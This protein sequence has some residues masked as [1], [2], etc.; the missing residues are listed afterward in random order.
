MVVELWMDNKQPWIARVPSL[1]FTDF[2]LIFAA[3]RTIWI[4]PIVFP[5]T[6]ASLID[7][8]QLNAL[9]TFRSGLRL[10]KIKLGEASMQYDADE[11]AKVVETPFEHLRVSSYLSLSTYLTLVKVSLVSIIL[12][13]RGS[14]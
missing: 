5:T 10:G 3:R 8:L 1:G 6:L 4:I 2:Y 11:P 9:S 14:G 7:I 12:G 13:Y